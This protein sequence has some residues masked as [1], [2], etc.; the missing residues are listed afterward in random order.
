[1]EP[2]V[3]LRL[4]RFKGVVYMLDRSTQK[5]YCYNPECPIEVG[6]WNRETHSV[7]FLK[8]VLDILKTGN[9]ETLQKYH[10]EKSSHSE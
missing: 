10:S 7:N 2:T 6:I 9:L 5:V 3:N 1:M 8:G 4:F